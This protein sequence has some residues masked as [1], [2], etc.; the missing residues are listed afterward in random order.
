MKLNKLTIIV[1]AGL[2]IVGVAAGI[3][4]V[5]WFVSDQEFRMPQRVEQGVQDVTP[6]DRGLADEAAAEAE[7]HDNQPYEEKAY[8][9]IGGVSSRVIVWVLAQL[10]LLFAAFVLAVPI[11]ALIIEFIG[12]KTGDKRYDKLAYE[13]TKLLSVS[14]SMTATFG[15]FLLFMLILLYPQLM[16]YLMHVFKPTFLPY[17]A[18]FFLEAAFLYSYYYGWGKF[19]PRVHLFLG[20]MLNLVGTAIMF[21][22]NAWL[23]FMTS[24]AGVSLKTGAVIST[25]RR[26]TTTPGCRSTSTASSPT[27]P[28]AARSPPPTPRSSSSPRATRTSRRTTT[29]WATSATS[30]RSARS[31]RCRSPATGWPPRSTPSTRRW[32][33]R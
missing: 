12:Y 18:L 24:P 6:R 1:L 15:A 5:T 17:V 7:K 21:I 14:F 22:A 33:C 29:G 8:R 31:C 30:S 2:L 13:F 10:H 4:A 25:G 26:S 19:G 28:S 11:F 27:S 16:Q 32:A 9:Q 3:R 20:F 23:T